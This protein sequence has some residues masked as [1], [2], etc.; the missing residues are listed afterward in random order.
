ML[1][2]D[3]TKH[4]SMA[5]LILHPQLLRWPLP[6]YLQVM[7]LHLSLSLTRYPQRHRYS[8]R[9]SQFP[10]ETARCR[11][12]ARLLCYS[13]ILRLLP[14]LLYPIYNTRYICRCSRTL[15]TQATI[16]L[17]RWAWSL[18]ISNNPNTILCTLKWLTC[19]DKCTP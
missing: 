16:L 1:Q 3:R 4:N 12:T 5:P 17:P 2:P 15:T 8:H 14:T 6:L 7:L 10:R 11:P 18:I 19:I 13:T 9:Y